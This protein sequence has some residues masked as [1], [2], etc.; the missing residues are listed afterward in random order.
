VPGV[1]VVPASC[2]ADVPPVVSYDRGV[3]LHRTFGMTRMLW[4]MLVAVLVCHKE[5]DGVRGSSPVR[6]TVTSRRTADLDGKLL[7]AARAWRQ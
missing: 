7:A 1:L 6:M 2:F 5:S 3:M 4:L